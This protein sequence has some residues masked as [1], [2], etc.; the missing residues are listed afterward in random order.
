MQKRLPI[1]A[2]LV[3]III[4]SDKTHVRKAYLIIAA[5]IADYPEQCLVCCCGESSCPGCLCEPNCRGHTT[6]SK[7]QCPAETLQ[8]LA[9]QSNSEYPVGLMDQHLHAIN[10]FWSDLPH[11]DMFRS[12]TPDLL[13]ELHNG[14]FGDH[15]VK[16]VTKAESGGEGEVDRRFRAMA[17]HPS[18]RHFKKGISLTTQWTGAELK[19]ME[20][21]FLGILAGATDPRVQLAVLDFIYYA[22]FETHC[23]ESLLQLEATWLALHA[24]KDVFVELGIREHF[25]ISKLHKL[26]HYVDSIR[27][28]GTADGFNTE[29]TERL[30]I[31]L[32]K[33]AYNASNKRAY[34]RHMTLWL[35]RQES[36]HK[37]G[38]YL[39]W[40]VGYLAPITSADSSD[41]EDEDVEDAPGQDLPEDSDDEGELEEVAASKESS[42]PTY[43]VAKKPGFPSLTA[44]AITTDFKAPDF[45]DNL[46]DFLHS[47]SIIPRLVPAD[48][49]TF[50]VSKKL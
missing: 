5:Y 19:N 2:T 12:M 30:H 26:K 6:H 43:I 24:N 44:K 17:P 41:D 25:N 23:D 20:K 32:A 39:Q 50:P 16:W 37:F 49:S 29:G 11:C 15:I 18:L 14:V 48:S 34:T 3:P 36:V 42:K 7:W 33:L 31:D 35:R 22:H 28:R 21:V 10:P 45:L 40:A 47:K 4:A 1:G 46:A 27:S 13:H 38:S 9:D 8:L